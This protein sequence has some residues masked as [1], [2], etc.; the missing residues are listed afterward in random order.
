LAL[1]VLARNSYVAIRQLNIPISLAIMLLLIV[2]TSVIDIT[3]SYSPPARSVHPLYGGLSPAQPTCRYQAQAHQPAKFSAGL[4]ER[5]T[6]PLW[7]ALQALW[8]S[9]CGGSDARL[10][11][12]WSE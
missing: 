11:D 10:R 3:C 5:A 12:H 7:F 2:T 1:A 8:R 4:V 9:V 6:G